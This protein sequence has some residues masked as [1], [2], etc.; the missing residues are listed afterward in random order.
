METET[1]K[2]SWLEKPIRDY[3]PE[4]NVETVIIILII[5]LALVSRFTMLGER[6]MSHDEINH[7]NPSYELYKGIHVYVHSAVT[8]GPLQFHLVA[9]S[10]FLFGDSDFS[11]RVPAAIFSVAAI[12]FVLFGFRRYLGRLGALISSVLFLISPFILYYGR[13]TR[14]EAFLELISVMAIYAILRYMDKKEPGALL[15]LTVAT[16]LHFTIKETAYIFVAMTLIFVFVLFVEQLLRKKWSDPYQKRIFLYLMMFIII[17]FAVVFV[18]GY[19]Q[20]HNLPS[21]ETL[22]EAAVETTEIIPEVSSNIDSWPWTKY[23]TIIGLILGILGAGYAVFL[24]YT[25]FSWKQLKE[26]PAFNLLMMQA[27][28]V[29]PLLAAFPLNLLG[30]NP[31]NY[32]IITQTEYLGMGIALAILFAISAFIGMLWDSKNWILNVTVFWVIF[33]LFYTTFFLNPGG[34][35]SGAIG[36]LGYWLSQQGVERGGQ[37]LYYYALVQIPVYEFLPAIGVL[38]ALVIG[39]RRRLFSSLPGVSPAAKENEKMDDPKR[40]PILSFLMYWT[41]VSLIAFS[42]AGE[43]MP[44]IT[45]HIAMP[46]ALTSGWAFGYFFEKFNWQ[47]LKKRLGWQTFLL[48]VFAMLAMFSVMYALIQPV[49]PFS[50][51]TLEQ[52]SITSQFIFWVLLLLA[53]IAGIIYLQMSSKEV[54]PVGKY[55]L[56]IILVLAAGQ[57]VRASYM[58]SFVNYDNAKEYLVYAH[59]ASGP[60]QVLSQIEEISRRITGGKNIDVAYDNDVNYPYWWYLRDY[61]NKLYYADQPSREIGQ[62]A[63]IAAGDS[64]MNKLEP[65]VKDNY[66]EYSYMRL[67]WPNQDY[68]SFVDGVTGKVN[69]EKLWSIVSDRDTV[70]G[71][72]KIWLNRDYSDYAEATGNTT[73]TLENWEPS[74]KMKFF[75]RKDIAAQI[76]DYGV[77]PENIT[78]QVGDP[79]E[80][81]YVDMT[82]VATYG[83]SGSEPGYFQAPRGIAVAPDNTFYVADSQNHRIQHFAENGVVIDTWGSFSGDVAEAPVGLFNEPWGVAVAPDGTVYVS[84]TWNHRIQ[85]FDAHGKFLTTWGFFGQAEAPDAFWGPRQITVDKDGYVYVADTGNKR[86]VIFTADGEFVNEFGIYGFVPGEFDEPTGVAVD[87]DGKVYVADTWNQRVQVFSAS[88]VFGI[89]TLEKYW[90]VSAWYGQSLDNKPFMAISDLGDIYISDPE[91]PRIIQF[92]NNGDIIRVWGDYSADLDG[93]GLASA[94]AIDQNGNVLVTDGS[95]NRVLRFDFAT[96]SGQ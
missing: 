70:R 13:Y 72:F 59:A 33:V 76:W 84:D 96:L 38:F 75:I 73:M 57:T 1:K 85:K 43:R 29:L 8:H 42:F 22:N 18:A 89:Y 64:T 24:V 14:N 94:V 12:I 69:W 28:L 77:I 41:I 65:I 31:Q 51:N 62:K 55:I 6:V 86:I 16:A 3:I 15:L 17:M 44:W 25:Q 40:I 20:A 81:F 46:M 52:L 32:E 48:V 50:G 79:Y 67:W 53:S 26:I 88:S 35:F 10:Y 37:P 95:K 34:F 83:F 54:M 61:P 71:I 19:I 66:I 2:A 21:A 92:T 23:T 36:G 45:V 74:S 9:L 80:G 63:L 11:S 90:D 7:V 82:A 91:G 39:V 68:M 49:L 56:L 78:E 87:N 4:F 30:M 27:T 5:L 93:F 58:S 60:K 47:Q